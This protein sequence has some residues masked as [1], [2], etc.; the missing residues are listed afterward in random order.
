VYDYEQK[1]FYRYAR[2]QFLAVEPGAFPFA[3]DTT[4]AVVHEVPHV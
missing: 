2:G 4:L 1:L 3:S